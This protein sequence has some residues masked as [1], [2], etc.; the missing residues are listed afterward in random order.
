LGKQTLGY[1][2]SSKLKLHIID[3]SKET[4]GDSIWA[5][6]AD[7]MNVAVGDLF[8]LKYADVDHDENSDFDADDWLKIVGKNPEVLQQPIVVN[9][10]KVK[11]ISRE[12]EALE[13]FGVDSAGLE[14]T[15]GHEDPTT[16]PTSNGETFV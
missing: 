10:D 12:T 9:G 1:L 6:L 8:S 14:K 15:F 4:L 5:E 13:F 7:N 2:K 11:Q 3:I 16:K